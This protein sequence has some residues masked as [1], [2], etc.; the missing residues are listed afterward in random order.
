M[1]TITWPHHGKTLDAIAA[2]GEAYSCEVTGLRRSRKRPPNHWLMRSV[3]LL[4]YVAA[5]I[6][7]VAEAPCGSANTT[8]E[9][10]RSRRRAL[11]ARRAF[12][13]TPASFVV[14]WR[15]DGRRGF[16]SSG[17][18]TT[19]STREKSHRQ[20]SVNSSVR[21]RLRLITRS[22]ISAPRGFT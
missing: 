21:R 22:N 2:V 15:D 20:L 9:Q 19:S 11:G 17:E 12:L 13:H 4:H 10:R 3:S 5:T 14:T 1:G 6:V 16:Y 8:S 18:E 7:M